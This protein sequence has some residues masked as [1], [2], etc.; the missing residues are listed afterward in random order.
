M[1][2]L[3][4]SYFPFDQPQIASIT[5]LDADGAPEWLFDHGRGFDLLAWVGDRFRINYAFQN[6]ATRVFSATIS[7][8]PQLDGTQHVITSFL[9]DSSGNQPTM[10]QIEYGLRDGELEQRVPAAPD[11]SPNYGDEY[12]YSSIA[13][14]YQALFERNDPLLALAILAQLEQPLP[15]RW[16]PHEAMVLKALA[17]EYNG[18][19][20]EAQQLLNVVAN[21][22]ETTGWSRF[23][24]QRR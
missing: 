21:D 10:S 9:P 16:S 1:A 19:F 14:V 13:T 2:T 23:V 18:Q 8:A 6:Q 20:V 17:L 22:S 12:N 24:Q 7:L 5:D 4:D 11:I 3:T 15:D